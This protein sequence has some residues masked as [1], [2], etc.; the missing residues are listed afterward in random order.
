MSLLWDSS[1]SVWFPMYM[2]THTDTWV[3]TCDNLISYRTR[4]FTS[5]SG[6]A[7]EHR[8]IIFVQ[9]YDIVVWSIYLKKGPNLEKIRTQMKLR[10][11]HLKLF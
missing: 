9:S 5:L 8:A 3:I 11:H 10:D 4:T 1:L 2:H 6:N 7:L